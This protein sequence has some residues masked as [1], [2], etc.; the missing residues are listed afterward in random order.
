MK[1]IKRMSL[2]PLILLFV[3]QVSAATFV[4]S[5]NSDVYHISSCG[6]AGKIKSEN[7]ITFRS[8]DA[9]EASGRHPC[10]F[11]RD[12]ISQARKSAAK[13]ATSS[14]KATTPPV[15]VP[16][17]AKSTST[18][19]TTSSTSPGYTPLTYTSSQTANY[20]K[21]LSS[22]SL[23]LF[24]ISVIFLIL[25]L[26]RNKSLKDSIKR[27]NSDLKSKE[28]ENK[29][30]LDSGAKLLGDEMLKNKLM[31]KELNEL[32]SRFA[33]LESKN[34]MLESQCQKLGTLL[35]DTDHSKDTLALSLNQ[36]KA[37]RAELIHLLQLTYGKDFLVSLSGAPRG[38]YIDNACLPH[39]FASKGDDQYTLHRSSTGKF[40]TKSCPHYSSCISIPA[41]DVKKSDF[42]QN[43]CMV[44]NPQYPD[45][46]WDIKYRHLIDITK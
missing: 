7:L 18:R 30:L 8:A 43:R 17:T 37:E 9:A 15:T 16:S 26:F 39:R 13:S 4:A 5:K 24:S 27:L 23:L 45:L 28:N 32:K 40:H 19:P 20:D 10:S 1:L 31:D 14:T 22:T 2:L 33:D 6:Q 44:C 42:N 41:L 34:A 25:Q 46:S 11:C 29:K 21:N 38:T 36:Y 35:S 3:I 12:E